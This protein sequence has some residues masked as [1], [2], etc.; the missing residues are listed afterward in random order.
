MTDAVET[1]VN[2]IPDLVGDFE[3]G[4][5]GFIVKNAENIKFTHPQYNIKKVD[6]GQ[7]D[8]VV[9]ISELGEQHFSLLLL[10]DEFIFKGRLAVIGPGAAF[11]FSILSNLINGALQ[12]WILQTTEEIVKVKAKLAGRTH[13][14]VP[15][16]VEV[17]HPPFP[18]IQS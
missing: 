15:L 3:N 18:E 12:K 9:S 7:Y 16:H 8:I 1:V 10:G 17:E 2:D 6:E 5:R 13:G 4:L 11:P 14:P